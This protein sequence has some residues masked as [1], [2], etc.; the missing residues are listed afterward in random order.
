MSI[1]IKKKLD[2]TK[3]VGKVENKLGILLSVKCYINRLIPKLL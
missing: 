3:E 2:I 1:G